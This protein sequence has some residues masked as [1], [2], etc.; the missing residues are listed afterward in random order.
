MKTHEHS[1]SKPSHTPTPWRIYKE[2]MNPNPRLMAEASTLVAVISQGKAFAKE[3]EANAAYIVKAV[4]AHEEMVKALKDVLFVLKGQA[5]RGN[6]LDSSERDIS[7][8]GVVEQAIA[9][10]EGK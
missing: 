10:A 5:E 8:E 6:F 3:T 7:L 2:P 1:L 4:N 9:K